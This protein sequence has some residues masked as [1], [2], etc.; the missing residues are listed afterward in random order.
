MREVDNPLHKTKSEKLP[1][2]FPQG[3][4]VYS[5]FASCH[6]EGFALI[7]RNEQPHRLRFE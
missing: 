1:E 4:K 2:G 6:P 3:G 5:Q 7:D